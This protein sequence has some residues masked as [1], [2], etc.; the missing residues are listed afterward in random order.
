MSIGKHAAVTAAGDPTG[1][2]QPD[3]QVL[4]LRE[5]DETRPADG[6]PAFRLHPLHRR[7]RDANRKVA[8]VE[9]GFGLGEALVSGLLSRGR[10]APRAVIV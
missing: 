7:P 4:G 6:L 10:W 9:A 5:I 1:M 2:S 3:C 8:C